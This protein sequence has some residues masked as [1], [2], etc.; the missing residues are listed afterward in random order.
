MKTQPLLGVLAAASVVV[1]LAGCSAG[2]ADP[3]GSSDSSGATTELQTVNVGTVPLPLFAPLFVADEK[4]YFADEGITLNLQTVT[5]GQDA[6]PLAANGQLDVLIAGFSAGMFNAVSAGLDVQVVGSMNIGDGVLDDPP[7]AIV[8]STRV[9]DPI[10]D[11]AGLEGRKVAIA[12]GLGGS[13]AYFVGE[14]LAREGLT[15][16]DITVENIGNADMPAALASGAVDAAMTSAPFNSN[17]VADGVATTVAVPGEGTSGTGVIY[18][19]QFADSDLAQPFFD[20]LARGA[21][22]LQ[23]G[24]IYED[25]NL[26]I[27]AEATSQDVELLRSTPLFVWLPDLAPQP[28]ALTF[29]EKVWRDAGAL[30]YSEPLDQSTFVNETFSDSV[31]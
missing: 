19:G 17:A 5:S 10:T 3:S 13:G 7:A 27:V 20:A 18:G 26:E 22:D 30:T 15:I 1:L 12:G 24:A 4:G 28:E 14:I 23:D 9:D 6:I 2:A 11:I 29:M 31:G 16:T 21:A 8:A 25:A